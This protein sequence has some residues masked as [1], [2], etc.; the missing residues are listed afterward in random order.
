MVFNSLNF[1]VIFLVA[2]SLY[3]ALPRR[4]QNILLLVSIYFFY[5]CWDWR[6]LLHIFISTKRM[7]QELT[8]Q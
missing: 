7:G 2:Y 3:L 5:G 4:P 6:F 8:A 1:L